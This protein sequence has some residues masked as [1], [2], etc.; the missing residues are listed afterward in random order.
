M[1]IALFMWI[2]I[3]GVCFTWGIIICRLLISRKLFFPIELPHFSLICLTGMAVAG[4]IAL[5]VSIFLPLNLYTHLFILLPALLC[6]LITPLR[7]KMFFQFRKAFSFSGLPLAIF[8]MAI[9][10]VLVISTYKIIHPDTLSYHVQSIIWFETFKAVPGT[11]HIDLELAFQSLWF[12]TNALFH[13]NFNTP[14]YAFYLNG[15]VLSW[16]FLFICGS[17]RV[18]GQANAKTA[19]LLVVLIF[20]LIS[21]TQVRLT[22]ASASPDFIVS[23]YI[24]GAGFIFLEG[25]KD[26]YYTHWMVIIFSMAAISIKLSA[27]TMALLPLMLVISWIK[28][29]KFMLA[30]RSIFFCLL[31][32]IPIL[33]RNSI[34]SGYPFYP[35]GFLNIMN[36]EWKLSMPALE[37]FQQYIM[38]YARIPV[39]GNA[40]T[41]SVDVH[42]NWIPAWWNY[43][44]TADKLL[45]SL[46]FLL[47]IANLGYLH[48][49]RKILASEEIMLLATSITGSILWFVLAPDPR[50]GTGFLML[51]AS[52]LAHILVKHKQLGSVISK[53]ALIVVCWIILSGITGYTLYRFNRF[54]E[55]DQVFY[56]KG[57]ELGDYK[58]VNCQNVTLYVPL[59]DSICGSIPAPCMVDSCNRVIP[60]GDVTTDGFLE[61][62]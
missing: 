15:A 6:W 62:K 36:V 35:S 47:A 58:M 44:A 39:D 54:F 13:W 1:L 55:P 46:I 7:S 11:V 3:T 5:Y 51:L 18:N 23:L 25:K 41:T 28:K 19:T 12:A 14:G 29:K 43:L 33:A 17:I 31:F 9:M 8:G 57:V 52:L 40:V 21:W 30:S 56:P 45:L 27:F 24:L 20:T 34:A 48:K 38:N 53:R 37:A 32:L 60:I 22:A 59:L 42:S 4:T 10:M 26:K 50:F 16:F 2:Y 49:S 61:K